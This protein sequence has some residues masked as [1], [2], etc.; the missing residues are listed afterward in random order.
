MATINTLQD[1][2]GH[3][4]ELRNLKLCEPQ[5]HTGASC[6]LVSYSMYWLNNPEIKIARDL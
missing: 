5:H 6:S 4:L 1:A 2:L 3:M